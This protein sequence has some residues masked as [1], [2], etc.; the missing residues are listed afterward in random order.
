MGNAFYC[1]IFSDNVSFILLSFSNLF[2]GIILNIC[3]DQTCIESCLKSTLNYMQIQHRN[4]VYP[5]KK[6]PGK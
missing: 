3:I 6:F 4:Y 5:K 1:L 2:H